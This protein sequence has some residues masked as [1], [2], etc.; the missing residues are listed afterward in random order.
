MLALN[1]GLDRGPARKIKPVNLAN[2]PKVDP[3][4]AWTRWGAYYEYHGDYRSAE[5]AYAQA[6]D[7]SRDPALVFSAGRAAECAGDVAQA[8]GFYTRILSQPSKT[9]NQPKK[10]S[11]LWTDEFDT[12]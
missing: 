11:L 8:V 3:V 7:K 12:A 1:S 5:A 6:L 2:Q 9:D 10:G 4:V